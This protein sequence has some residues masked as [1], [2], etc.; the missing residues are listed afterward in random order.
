MHQSENRGSLK[1]SPTYTVF[2][3]AAAISNP[4]AGKAAFTVSRETWSR[5]VTLRTKHSL[6]LALMEQFKFLSSRIYCSTILE[7]LT[8]V[9][10]YTSFMIFLFLRSQDHLQFL[11]SRLTVRTFPRRSRIKDR[12]IGHPARSA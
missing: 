6:T 1:M 7:D 4:F 3:L 8:R 11:C 9:S 12:R 2:L 5:C 10:Y